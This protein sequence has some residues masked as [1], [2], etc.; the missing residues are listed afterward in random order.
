[1]ISVKFDKNDSTKTVSLEVKGHAGQA[2]AGKD[3]IC[4]SASI[5]SYTVAQMVAIM[6]EQGKLT[7]KPVIKIKEG[8]A[9]IP[10]QAKTDED[11]A[12][13]LHTY[14]VARVGYSLLAHNYP[15]YVELN[16]FGEA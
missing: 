5:L 15:Q 2:E 6:E 1:M 14:Y 4:A 8:D 16:T 3:I 10:C 9:V 7:K 12:E 13:A 11:Y